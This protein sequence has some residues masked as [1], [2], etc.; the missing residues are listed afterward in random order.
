MVIASA[1]GATPLTPNRST[2]DA[3]VQRLLSECEAAI[4]DFDWED[5]ARKA[6]FTTTLDAL[7]QSLARCEGVYP[8]CSKLV[9][10][11]ARLAMC[12]RRWDKAVS[13]WQTA[14]QMDGAIAGEGH[15]GL[16]Q[17]YLALDDVDKAEEALSLA[18][19][20][21][22]DDPQIRFLR[23]RIGRIKYRRDLMEKISRAYVCI[24]SSADRDID[25]FQI[26]FSSLTKTSSAREARAICEFFATGSKRVFPSPEPEASATL[27]AVFVC[28]IGWSGSG[29]LVDFLQSYSGVNFPLGTREIGCFSG[30]FG[31]RNLAKWMANRPRSYR[32]LLFLFFINHV[33]GLRFDPIGLRG[34]PN[35]TD[36]LRHCGSSPE[37]EIHVLRSCLR[38]LYDVEAATQSSCRSAEHYRNIFSTFFRTVFSLRSPRAGVLGFNNCLFGLSFDAALLMP[39]PVILL[40]VREPRDVLVA[41]ELEAGLAAADTAGDY[42]ERYKEKA[43]KISAARSTDALKD[44]LCVVR[45]EDFVLKASLRDQILNLL[46]LENQKKGGNCRF[47]P[48]VSARN[49]GLHRTYCDQEL[50]HDVNRK[51]SPHL[52]APSLPARS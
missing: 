31:V 6:T 8:H 41:R 44:I 14:C 51:L 1:W 9:V 35:T 45:F 13:K 24:E 12:L 11:R 43:K 39:N 50:L 2:V 21:V 27:S 48:D 33:F 5:E 36:I 30:K 42:V 29:A 32:S 15:T 16:A 25:I 3:S 17:C 40:S 47:N 34:R 10:T 7:D 37:E 4:A 22:P 38:L 23:K 20:C 46:N 26:L 19:T 49:I 52:I 28:G 18:S